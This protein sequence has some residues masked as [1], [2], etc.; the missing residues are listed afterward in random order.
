MHLISVIRLLLISSSLRMRSELLLIEVCTVQEYY[1]KLALPY[2]Q[3][4]RHNL[5]CWSLC[6]L[7]AKY[8]TRVELYASVCFFFFLA[9]KWTSSTFLSG[10]SQSV[11]QPWNQNRAQL[12]Q[13]N[14]NEYLTNH[15]WKK[16]EPNLY[17]INRLYTQRDGD[18]LILCKNI[19]HT[20][21]RYRG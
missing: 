2:C 7:P 1:R 16:P 9:T 6:S 21:I 12:L 19:F 15:T 11:L 20:F 4:S 17:N 18:Q 3:P 13:G 14:Q 5:L 10:F 8:L